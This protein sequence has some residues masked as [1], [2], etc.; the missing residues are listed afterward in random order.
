M[1]CGMYCRGIIYS[2]HLRIL[3]FTRAI[4]K[5]GPPVDGEPIVLLLRFSFC[6]FSCQEA[7]DFALCHQRN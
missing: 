2:G 3:P 1:F 6:I 7:V 4:L 5:V